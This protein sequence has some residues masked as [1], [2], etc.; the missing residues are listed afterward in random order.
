MREE[1]DTKV[2]NNS[3]ANHLCPFIG[4]C[5]KKAFWY[6]FEMLKVTGYSTQYNKKIYCILMCNKMSTNQSPIATFYFRLIR[7]TTNSFVCYSTYVTTS[8]IIVVR[9]YVIKY[10]AVCS[11]IIF[12][13]IVLHS[14]KSADH[15][16]VIFCSSVTNYYLNEIQI[17]FIKI[18][19]YSLV[20]FLNYRFFLLMIT[21]WR[22]R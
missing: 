21:K 11:D 5:K 22:I 17:N 19:Y 14:T 7:E 15:Q 9:Y 18:S 1:K 4:L 3:S 20:C 12:Y 10:F 2:L 16:L 13:A 8:L 6:L